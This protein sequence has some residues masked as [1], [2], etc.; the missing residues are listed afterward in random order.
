MNKLWLRLTFAFLLVAW[1]SI[2][3][4][5]LVVQRSTDADFRQYV[6]QSMNA[7]GADQIAQIE[8][9][10][11][12]NGSWAGIESLLTGRSSGFQRQ[13]GAGMG[14]HGAQLLIVDLNGLVVA[15]SDSTLVSTSIA[16]DTLQRGVAL[17]ANGQ[18]IGW[19]LR[20]S[21]GMQAMGTAETAFLDEANRWLAAAAIG[22]TGLA[23]VVGVTL[24]WALSRPLQTL[25]RAVQTLSGGKLG[26]QVQVKGTDEITELSEAFNTMSRSLA[27]AESLRER[28]AADIAHELRTPV[29]ILRGHLEAMLDGVYPLDSARVA[30]AH[31]QTL[32]LARLVDDLRLLTLAE[33]RRLPLEKTFV[34]PEAL[35]QDSFEA[36]EPLAADLGIRLSQ[37]IAPNLPALE[38][39]GTRIRQV[40]NN[41]VTNALRHTPSGGE[42]GVSVAQ[43]GAR[44]RFSVSNTGGD[45]AESELLRVFQPFW[46]AEAARERDKGGSG[47]GLAI[48]QQIIQLHGGKIWAERQNGQTFFIFE[49]PGQS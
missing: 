30:V 48:S 26:Q 15:G 9:Y 22:A 2:I 4:L 20:Q 35:A 7:V 46:R 11:A 47:L 13:Q 37:T 27:E 17:D 16:E 34:Q 42:I 21:P 5:A 24:A 32:H 18:Q 49:I 19:L 6:N 38:M 43:V 33:A 12:A 36:F 25:T 10:Y 40:L 39:D 44:L 31:E 3:A 45:L 29:S 23:L 14:Q 41:L 1:V 8:A 28:M